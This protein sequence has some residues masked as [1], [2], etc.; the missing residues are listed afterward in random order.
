MRRGKIKKIFFV[1]FGIFCFLSGVLY[2]NLTFRKKQTLIEVKKTEYENKLI[3]VSRLIVSNTSLSL[4]LL[5]DVAKVWDSAINEGLDFNPAI[6]NYLKEEKDTLNKLTYLNVE[7]EKI[8]LEVKVCPDKYLEYHIAIM[9]LYK[10]Y[11]QIYSL[12]QS[13][14]GSL[15][16]FSKKVNDLKSEFIKNLNTLKIYIPKLKEGVASTTNLKKGMN[17][18]VVEKLLGIPQEKKRDLLGREIWIY[19]SQQK[20]LTDRIYFNKGKV[21]EWR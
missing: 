8:M 14:T 12:S 3:R 18:T 2:S 17:L 19:P 20:G 1:V 4:M 11:N 10:V 15:I 7:I 16:N 6:Q 13:P 9:D 5:D 21:S